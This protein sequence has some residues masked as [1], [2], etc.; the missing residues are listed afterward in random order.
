MHSIKNKWNPKVVN[1]SRFH[2]LSG[3]YKYKS[4]AL[5]WERKK[6]DYS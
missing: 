3:Q 4:G 2:T 5:I 1:F 6:A